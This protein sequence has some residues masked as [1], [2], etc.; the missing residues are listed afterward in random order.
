MEEEMPRSSPVR[1]YAINGSSRKNGQTARR[2]NSI[3]AGLRRRR[4]EADL[5]HL[6]DENLAF[7]DGRQEPTSVPPDITTLLKKLRQADGII[8]GTPTYW[9]NMSG[10]MKNFLDR[11]VVTDET[12]W[13]L[14]GTVVGFVATGSAQEDGAMI[15]LSTMAATANH[16]GLITFPYSMIYFR[17]SRGPMWAEGDVR[18]YAARMVTMIQLVR[19]HDGSW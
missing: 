7:S 8:L 3:V 15:A 10:L 1:V 2:L 11:L 18:R 12:K 5:I 17:G 9:F 14:K 4:A 16:L 19:R 6:V 13:T